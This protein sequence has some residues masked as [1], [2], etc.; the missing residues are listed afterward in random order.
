MLKTLIMPT[1]KNQEEVAN[2]WLL[3]KR[4]FFKKS[5]CVKKEMFDVNRFFH[6]ELFL[7]TSFLFSEHHRREIKQLFLLI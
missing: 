2:S 6:R 5:L 4:S 7:L 3:Y 1:I